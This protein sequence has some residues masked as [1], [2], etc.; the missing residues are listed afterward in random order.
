MSKVVIVTGASSGIGQSIARY[1]AEKGHTVYGTSRSERDDHESFHWLQLDVNVLKQV[2]DAMANVSKKH[3]RIDAV[4]NNAGLGMISSLEEAPPTNVD[5]VMNT[6]FG[7]VLRVCQT[8]LPLMRSQGGGTIINISSVAGL[9]GLPYR[10]IYSASKFAVEG[11]TEAMRTEVSK[12][13]IKV[14]SLQ[15][16]SIVTDIKAGRVSY[17]PENSPYQPEL[18]IAERII[19]TEVMKGIPVQRVAEAVEMLIR[20]KKIA[21]KYAVAKPFQKLSLRLKRYLPRLWFERMLM[22]HYRIKR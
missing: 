19:D 14:C 6:N 2:E 11:L 10:S 16:G 8:V 15:P 22:N 9:M 13:G 21:P 5:L 17:M 3:G 18:G 20:A 12:F 1:L 7:G 4:I